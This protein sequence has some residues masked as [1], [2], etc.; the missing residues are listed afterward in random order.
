M[1]SEFDSNQ[2][3]DNV[4]VELLGGIYIQLLRIYDLLSLI[5]PKEDVQRLYNLHESGRVL[6]PDP[7]LVMDEE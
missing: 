4:M 6:A 2:E 7:A 5:A 1:D 3:S